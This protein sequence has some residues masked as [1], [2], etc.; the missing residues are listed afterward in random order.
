MNEWITQVKIDHRQS[1]ERTSER[2]EKKSSPRETEQTNRFNVVVAVVLFRELA[3]MRNDEKCLSEQWWHIVEWIF[4]LCWSLICLPFVFVR[5]D[6]KANVG[7]R[8]RVIREFFFV[9]SSHSVLLL[10]N[11]IVVFVF[12]GVVVVVVDDGYVQPPRQRCR[13]RPP[14]S[15]ILFSRLS[16][17]FRVLSRSSPSSSPHRFDFFSRSPLLRWMRVAPLPRRLFYACPATFLSSLQ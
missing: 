8:E 10:S 9:L 3:K 12:L 5:R 13:R 1:N 7:R 2:Q 4:L 16:S 17:L 15:P 14:T 6:T 11:A